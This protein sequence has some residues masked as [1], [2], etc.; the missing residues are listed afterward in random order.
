MTTQAELVQQLDALQ[1]RLPAMIADNPDDGD[2]WMEFAGVADTIEPA[3][4]ELTD[5]FHQR[6]NQMLAEHGRY[7]AGV[8]FEV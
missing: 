6:I 3:E 1:A 5:L 2:F 4:P 7:I 8:D